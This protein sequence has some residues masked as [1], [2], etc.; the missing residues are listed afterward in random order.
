MKKEEFIKE[1]EKLPDG[2]DIC[3]TDW[4]KN[5]NRANGSH[6][7]STAGVYS[8]FEIG[9]AR[10][11]EIADNQEPFAFIS[12]ENEDYESNAATNKITHNKL[13]FRLLINGLSTFGKL[14]ELQG[15]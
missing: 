4:R 1:I 15:R 13:R 8:D 9:V 11:D 14:K 12:F 10:K 6:E 7:G 2:I 3:I 5:L